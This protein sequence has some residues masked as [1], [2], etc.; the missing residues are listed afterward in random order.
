MTTVKEDIK[1]IS[2]DNQRLMAIIAPREL[3]SWRAARI[4]QLTS[5]FIAGT[6]TETEFL[7]D[8]RQALI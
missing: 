1:T 6:I 4:A 8:V 2:R 3:E 7:H 5:E